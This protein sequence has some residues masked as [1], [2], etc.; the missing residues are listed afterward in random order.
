MMLQ[1]IITSDSEHTQLRQHYDMPLYMTHP[2][3]LESVKRKSVGLYSLG[4]LEMHIMRQGSTP[5]M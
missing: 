2:N 4:M 3:V 1:F 5:D